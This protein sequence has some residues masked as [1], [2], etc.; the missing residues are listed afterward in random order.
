M[1]GKIGKI[2]TIGDLTGRNKNAHLKLKGNVV[3]M[4]KAVLG[5]QVTSIASAIIDGVVELAGHH[6]TCQLISST[7]PDPSE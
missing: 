6:V 5:L 2:G 4:R 3:L 1:L 7:V